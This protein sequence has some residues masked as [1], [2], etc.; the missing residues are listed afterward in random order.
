MAKCDWLGAGCT[1]TY[2]AALGLLSRER[3]GE[4]E[5]CYAICLVYIAM[6]K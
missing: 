2:L 3:T 6:S 4:V 1:L 5:R